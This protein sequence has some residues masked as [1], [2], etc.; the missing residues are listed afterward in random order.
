MTILPSSL[1][2]PTLIQVPKAPSWVAIRDDPTTCS[3]GYDN[4]LDLAGF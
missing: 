3:N 1:S 4:I 2:K